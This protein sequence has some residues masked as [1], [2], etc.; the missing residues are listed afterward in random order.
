MRVGMS[1]GQE[2]ERKGVQ[3]GKYRRKRGMDPPSEEEARDRATDGA[4]GVQDRNLSQSLI[5]WDDA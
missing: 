2:K 1:G 4:G 3:V 5:A